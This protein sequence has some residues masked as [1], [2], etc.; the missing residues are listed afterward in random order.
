[1]RRAVV[2]SIAAALIIQVI[3]PLV[4]LRGLH[5]LFAPL[6][7]PCLAV[8]LAIAGY[9]YRELLLFS[10]AA[11]GAVRLWGLGG[12][13]TASAG[14][15][16]GVL[17][18]TIIGAGLIVLAYYGE[19]VVGVRLREDLRIVASRGV[20]VFTY[21]MLV[22]ILSLPLVLLDPRLVLV[23]FA[24]NLAKMYGLLLIYTS[25]PAGAMRST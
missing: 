8:L 21:G 1:M 13:M 6:L 23:P 19:L 5:G 18:D 9:V 3:L 15:I 22:F 25:I 2:G 20:D 11:R 7:A 12:I 10:Q 17:G 24:G 16:L 14:F 4:A